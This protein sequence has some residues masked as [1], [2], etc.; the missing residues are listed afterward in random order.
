MEY[1]RLNTLIHSIEQVKLLAMSMYQISDETEFRKYFL[2]LALQMER[3]TNET[4]TATVLD[5]DIDR[6]FYLSEAAESL[7]ISVRKYKDKLVIILPYLLPKRQSIESDNY[8]IE[9]LVNVLKKYVDI[10]K[11]KKLERSLVVVKSVYSPDNQLPTEDQRD[12][13]KDEIE[14]NYISSATVA[15]VGS[16]P[17]IG[18]TTQALQIVKHL[19][20][21]GYTAC[22]IQLNSSDHVQRIAEFYTDSTQDEDMG[23]VTYQNIEMYYR[24]EKI[25]DILAK[26]Y[27]Y[28]IYD[29]GCISDKDFTLVQFLE[30]DIKIAICGSKANELPQIQSVLEQLGNTSADYIFSFTSEN[31]QADIIELMEEKRKHT[32]FTGYIPDPFSYAPCSEPIFKAVIKPDKPKNQP[33]TKKHR[34]S[35]FAWKKAKKRGK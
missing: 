13:K 22:Y 6:K 7:D 17:R 29:F 12:R 27:D 9:P 19:I 2:T 25:A 33:D 30:K 35:L 34:F 1:K 3:L 16:T 20:L 5:A 15:V 23:R 14:G 18:T 4:R 24:Q 26:N 32:Y 10:N 21:Q 8:I 31:D 11:P 28:Y